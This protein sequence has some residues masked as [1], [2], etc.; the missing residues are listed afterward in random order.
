MTP[1]PVAVKPRGSGKV[2]KRPFLLL[3]T[4]RPEIQRLTAI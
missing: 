1:G 2:D 4:A 3:W